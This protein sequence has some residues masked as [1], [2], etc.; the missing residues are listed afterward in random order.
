MAGLAPFIRL[1]VEQRRH[2]RAKPLAAC[3]VMKLAMPVLLEI[4]ARQLQRRLQLKDNLLLLLKLNNLRLR[5][6]L[7]RQL[8]N[9]QQLQ[10]Q[11]NQRLQDFLQKEGDNLLR[12]QPVLLSQ[13]V[14]QRRP[15]RCLLKVARTNNY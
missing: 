5:L 1:V 10:L 11:N 6:I 9:Q 4:E 13:L 15:Q 12:L 2:Q 8:A 7:L 3:V 14:L